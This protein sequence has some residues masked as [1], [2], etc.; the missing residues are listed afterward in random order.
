MLCAKVLQRAVSEGEV[1][2]TLI[3]PVR[4]TRIRTCIVSVPNFSIP[5]LIRVISGL[6]P[7]LSIANRTRSLQD[8]CSATILL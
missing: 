4:L 7:T 6:N 1:D 5:A 2:G 3:R 8:F